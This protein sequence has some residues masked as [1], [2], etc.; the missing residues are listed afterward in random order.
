MPKSGQYSTYPARAAGRR[1]WS[2]RSTIETGLG[3]SGRAVQVPVWRLLLV[4]SDAVLRD[5]R[6]TATLTTLRDRPGV[7][8]V[9]VTGRNAPAR[10]LEIA[11]TVTE[12]TKRKHPYDT[13]QR[14]QAGIS[15]DVHRAPWERERLSTLNF[16]RSPT[17]N[18][19]PGNYN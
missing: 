13:G 18:N 9:V 3:R 14:G 11:T 10:L 16:S 1:T 6:R 4:S 2:G 7:Q 19:L 15:V 12:M 17:R 8:H 5:G